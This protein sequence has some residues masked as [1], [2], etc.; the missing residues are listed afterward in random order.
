MAIPKVFVS[1]TWYDLKFIRENLQYFI[2]T[3][4][5]EPV[6]FEQGSIYFD[7]AK[8]VRHA[9]TGEVENCQLFVLVIGGRYGSDY[10][11]K[12]ISVTNAEYRAA[13]EKRIPVFA[14]I[15]DSVLNEYSVYNRNL[16]AKGEDFAKGIVYP[17]V[18]DPRVFAFISEVISNRTNNAIFGFKDF[19]DMEKYLKAQW[20]GMM[21]S[22]LSAASESKR[23]QDYLHSVQGISE[24][25]EVMTSKIL[26]SV[27]SKEAKLT[28]ALYSEMVGHA[29]VGKLSG[30]SLKPTIGDVIQA[31]SLEKYFEAKD[32]KLAIENSPSHSYSSTLRPGDKLYISQ[33]AMDAFSE[34]YRP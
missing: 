20:A 2:S 34:E 5:Y 4:G 14:L 13:V 21:F 7:P 19:A 31:K 25:I 9:A 26:D 15:E 17:S 24:K 11:D 12:N 3:L 28:A 32:T 18:D 16:S 33:G 23:F 30:W 22:F 8:E 27:G 1:S 6:L 10:I 29:I